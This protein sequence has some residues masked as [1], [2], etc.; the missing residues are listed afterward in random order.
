M[1]REKNGCDFPIR[2]G[3]NYSIYA[4]APQLNGMLTSCLKLG[5][6]KQRCTPLRDGK[7][8]S[9]PKAAFADR[10]S[11]RHYPSWRFGMLGSG[12]FLPWRVWSRNLLLPD[13]YS[14]RRWGMIHMPTFVSAPGARGGFPVAVMVRWLDI[15]EKGHP[16]ICLQIMQC[17]RRRLFQIDDMPDY[18]VHRLQI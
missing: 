17:K 5:R 9:V 11:G 13:R 15:S 14:A 4:Y 18:A 6:R 7:Y 8:L 12:D 16:T 3:E 2:F 1:A 10:T